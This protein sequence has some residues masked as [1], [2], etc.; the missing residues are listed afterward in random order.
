M[1]VTIKV[2]HWQIIHTI[3]ITIT[4]YMIANLDEKRRTSSIKYQTQTEIN[5]GHMRLKHA[6]IVKLI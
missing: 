1:I 6:F 3:L 5:D 2:L 4:S